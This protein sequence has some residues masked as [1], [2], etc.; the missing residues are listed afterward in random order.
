MDRNRKRQRAFLLPL[1]MVTMLVATAGGCTAVATA[2]Y[3][4]KGTNVDAEFDGLKDKRVAVVCR[5]VVALDY[6]NGAV[7]KDL[8]VAVGH[9][10]KQNVRK[11]EL[12]DPSEVDN[13]CDEND[14]YN[15]TEVGEAVH[16]DVVV[17][18]ELEQFSLYE[19]LTLYRGRAETLIQVYDM[20]AGG[21]LIW[22]KRPGTSEYPPNISLDR[23]VKDENE[24]R[25]EYIQVLAT[26]IG[27]H[28]YAHDTRV[29]FAKD[30][31]AYQ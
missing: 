26:E 22:Q 29:D 18:I 7:A 31:L 16:A 30:T 23:S 1:G 19:S 25:T 4:I 28:F 5:P 11:I 17:A 2:L 15:F 27:R 24:F 6:Q 9:L 12:V 8:A 21:D 3:V 10:L 14:W 20:T 13:W